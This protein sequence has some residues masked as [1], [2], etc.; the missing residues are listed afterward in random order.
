MSARARRWR[1]KGRAEREMGEVSIRRD[2]RK[3]KHEAKTR[4]AD[5][6]GMCG[7]VDVCRKWKRNKRGIAELTPMTD[8]IIFIVYHNSANTCSF[9]R[10]VMYG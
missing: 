8:L 7:R 10:A 2:V 6:E 1:K 5:T 4:G 9:V 3:E